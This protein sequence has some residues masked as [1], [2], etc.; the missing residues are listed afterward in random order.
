LFDVNNLVASGALFASGGLFFNQNQIAQK[1]GGNS[2]GFPSGF[3]LSIPI[4]TLP[5]DPDSS[6]WGYLD[7]P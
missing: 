1:T 7:Y 3:A 6:Y 5:S 2:L 4:F